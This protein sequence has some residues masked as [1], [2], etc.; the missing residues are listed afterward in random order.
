MGQDNNSHPVSIRSMTSGILGQLMDKKEKKYMHFSIYVLLI[1]P[2][3]NT[4]R[5]IKCYIE[6]T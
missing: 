3:I 1:L 6:S 4:M 2:E 5:L